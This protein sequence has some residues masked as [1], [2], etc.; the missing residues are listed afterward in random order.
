MSSNLIAMS[1]PGNSPAA[2]PRDLESFPVDAQRQVWIIGGNRENWYTV[3]NFSFGSSLAFSVA[4]A[5]HLVFGVDDGSTSYH[6]KFLQDTAT[7]TSRFVPRDRPDLV[8]EPDPNGALELS[9]YTGLP[10]QR[11]VSTT[12]F[13]H[14]V[15]MKVT[16]GK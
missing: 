7:G 14:Q 10:I 12:I 15:L 8:L 1:S 6:L 2:V 3:K 11:L 4:T 9:P 5:S 16:G 13:T